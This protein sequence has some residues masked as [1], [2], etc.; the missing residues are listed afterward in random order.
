MDRVR[1][2]QR[3]AELIA[4]ER[5]PSQEAIAHRLAREGVEVTQATLS[6]DLREIGAVKGVEG[7]RLSPLAGAR[8][9]A[10]RVPSDLLRTL[11][12]RVSAA[13]TLVVV[14]TGPGQAQAVASELDRLAQ[15]DVV[16]SV[17]GD[18]T[19]FVAAASAVG[20]RRLARELLALSGLKP[21]SARSG[22]ARPSD[23]SAPGRPT[24]DTP[25]WSGASM[26]GARA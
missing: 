14:R 13:G 10:E 19:V 3:V 21:P 26:T 7:Y 24:A 25:T 15:P 16:G 22:A 1:R 23:Q 11:V 12:Q 17:A 8:G 4:A 20:A 18:D 2:R 5:L 9:Q 6:R